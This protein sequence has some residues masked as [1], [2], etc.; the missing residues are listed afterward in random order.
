MQKLHHSA[1]KGVLLS[2]ILVDITLDG[3]EDIVA[4]MFNSTIV[5]YDGKSFQQIWN[6]TVP[7]SEVI[8][9]P[10]PGYYDDDNVPDFMVKHQMGPGIPVYYYTVAT[11]LNGKTGKPILEEPMEDSMSAQMSGLS[12]SVQGFG[13]DWFLHWSADCLKHEGSKEKYQFFKGQN[14]NSQTRADLCKLRFNSTLTSSLYAFSQHVGPPGL[15]LYFSEDWKKLEFNNSFDP[16]QAAENYIE[17][18]PLDEPLIQNEDVAER[19]PNLRIGLEPEK[20]FELN[21]DFFKERDDKYDLEDYKDEEPAILNF[22]DKVPDAINIA[23]ELRGLDKWENMRPKK[24]Y[25]VL[26]DDGTERLDLPQSEVRAQRSEN[27][28]KVNNDTNDVQNKLDPSMDY[29]NGQT[30]RYYSL[31][32]VNRSNS[33][34]EDSD[35]FSMSEDVDFT[36][37]PEEVSDTERKRESRETKK[38]S[39]KEA[40]AEKTLGQK[41]IPIIL[42]N[43]NDRTIKVVKKPKEKIS[44]KKS[45]QKK[46]IVLKNEQEEQ[47]ELA[48]KKRI[49]KRSPDNGFRNIVTGVQRQPPT[50]ILL[51]SLK[52]SKKRSIDLVFSTYWL[53]ATETPI[54]LLQQ[55]LDCIRRKEKDLG[56]KVELAEY[57]INVKECLTERGF[58]YKFFE[59]AIDREN[60][61]IALGQ[62]TVY[63]MQLQCVC[64]EDMAPGKICKDISDRQSWPAHLGSAGNGYFKPL[65]SKN[66]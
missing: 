7:N 21:D 64:P 36:D 63:R 17:N 28:P 38:A 62:M 41:E 29:T 42:Q 30:K 27:I 57:D 53:P 65:R 31:E 44:R 9:I 39:P 58:N 14:T 54:V 15:P 50:G 22:E 5:A 61:K 25:D 11:I 4:A 55:D 13:N 12:L 24:V 59:E 20:K 51:P 23:E 40:S 60:V 56:R 46:K 47:K 18:Y 2:P 43:G 16:R 6:Y 10:I 19:S 66:S 33:L 48:R 32:P 49:R 34:D 1:G 37:D 3:T 26:Y 52:S 35:Y 45:M 8:S